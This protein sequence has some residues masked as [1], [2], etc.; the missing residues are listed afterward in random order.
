MFHFLTLA[1]QV[2][3]KSYNLNDKDSYKR[4]LLDLLE[5]VRPMAKKTGIKLDDSLLKQLEFIL[6]NDLLFDYVYKL[7]FQQLQSEEILLE[8]VDEGTILEL[9]ENT[10]PDNTEYPEAINPIVIVSLVSQIIS[11]I[12]AIKNR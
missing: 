3:L 5:L 6:N 7:V 2:I 1:A 8:S 10:V 11:I 12:N 4:F 9:C